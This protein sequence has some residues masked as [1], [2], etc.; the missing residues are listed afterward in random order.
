M[1]PFD[2]NNLNKVQLKS[3]FGIG[4]FIIPPFSSN[5]FKE[6][7]VAE[8]AQNEEHNF[9]PVYLN[10]DYI[11]DSLVSPSKNEQYDIRNYL[12]KSGFNNFK[13]LKSD[14]D[15]AIYIMAE[16]TDDIRYLKNNLKIFLSIK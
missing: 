10:G 5:A 7:S 12:R 1:H 6:G 3:E 16:N 14:A 2:F 9:V 4:G 11:G 13:I 15:G 8:D